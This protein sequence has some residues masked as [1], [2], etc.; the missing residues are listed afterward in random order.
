MA[1][2]LVTLDEM[3]T[4][5]GID[6]VNTDSDVFL[7]REIGIISEAIELFCNRKF[8]AADYI[9]NFYIDDHIGINERQKL[10]L[11][12]FPLQSITSVK[13]IVEDDSGS[14]EII[15]SANQ[16]R[17][18]KS[19]AKIQRISNGRVDNW[20][21]STYNKI[22][23]TFNAGLSLIPETVKNVVYALVSERYSKDKS[24]ANVNFG[25]DVQRMSI[26]GVMS[27]DFDYSLQN[28]ERKNKF[29][30]V[31][32]NHLNVLDYF[33]SEAGVMANIKEVYLD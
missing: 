2:M 21:S 22:E 13:E 15:L 27:L 24:G 7:T 8:F 19:S 16:F 1:T 26:P 18:N 6:L 29:G 23:I 32:G 12:S 5:L 31:L 20:F 30:M 25:N 3:K 9:Q 4:Y 28:N 17:T 10:Y 33:R 14:S 11:A